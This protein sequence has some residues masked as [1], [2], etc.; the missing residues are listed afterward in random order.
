MTDEELGTPRT[1]ASRPAARPSVFGYV[2][3]DELI[4]RIDAV[5]D[6]DLTSDFFGDSIQEVEDAATRIFDIGIQTVTEAGEPARGGTFGTP[7][8]GTGVA[9]STPAGPVTVCGELEDDTAA[10]RAFILGGPAAIHRT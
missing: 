2:D 1:P 5:A 3:Q 7:R 10:R 6:D 8:T 4:A 9:T